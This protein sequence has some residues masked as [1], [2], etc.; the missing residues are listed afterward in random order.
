MPEPTPLTAEP[1]DLLA[2]VSAQRALDD[3]ALCWACI[4]T[5]RKKVAQLEAE[6]MAPSPRPE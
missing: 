2:Q 6:A 1:A 3:L 4:T 5:L